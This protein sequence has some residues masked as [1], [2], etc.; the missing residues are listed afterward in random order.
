MSEGVQDD[1]ALSGAP[2]D[3]QEI[4]RKFALPLKVGHADER[5]MEIALGRNLTIV[6][7]IFAAERGCKAEELILFREGED[8]PLSALIVINADYP[9]HRRHHVHHIGDVK[10]S[11]FYKTES[12]HR[13]FKRQ[14]TVEDVL[15]WAI[16]VF[17]IDPSMATEFELARHDKKE[18]LPGTE[19]IGHLA[20]KEHTLQ[21]DLVRGDIANG[22]GA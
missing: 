22:C 11:I 6:L 17:G 2:E 9:H 15:A 10:V 12:R 20:G 16:K 5:T 21:L 4:E 1:A 8:E 18:E 13:E 3:A 7:E 14:S 19:H